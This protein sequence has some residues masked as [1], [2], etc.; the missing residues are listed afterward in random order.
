MK[1]R[2]R[3]SSVGWS[4]FALA[5]GAGLACVG[6]ARSEDA[7]QVAPEPAFHRAFIIRTRP[8]MIVDS[9][10]AKFV[11]RKLNR[12]KRAGADLVILEI[13]SPGGRMDASLAIAEQLRRV[14]WARTVAYI[15]RE[16]ISGAAVVALGCDEIVMQPHARLGD[17]GVIVRDLDGQFH[18]APEKIQSYLIGNLRTLA[19]QK[20]RPPAIAEAMVNKQLVV[21]RATNRH[22]GQIH[23]LSAPEFN[24]LPDK[25]Q[26]DQGPPIQESQQGLFL[27]V[28]GERAVELQLAQACVEDDRALHDRYRVANVTV[29]N[30]TAIDSAV[31]ILNHPFLAG[32]LLVIGVI[33][34]VVELSAPGIGFG[35]LTSGLCFALFFWSHFLGGTSGWLEVILFIAG[36]TFLGM[37]LFVFPGFGVAGVTGIVLLLASLIMACIEFSP[38]EGVSLGTLGTTLGMVGGSGL[39]SVVGIAWV[40]KH[41]G[42]I[43]LL[44]GLTLAP[45]PP[46]DETPAVD[47][48]TGKPLPKLDDT[49][50][51]EGAWGVTESPLRPSGKAMF[52]DRYVDVDAAG[53]FVEKGKQVRITSIMGTRIIVHEIDETES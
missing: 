31:V 52:G 32:L 49:A 37:E 16:A 11:S 34:L 53:Y 22:T 14:D 1:S 25:D 24:E 15:P 48:K 51:H 38:R 45:P 28:G 46:R 18:Y 4:T 20:G 41:L 10:M 43:R 39:A 50:I 35:G 6:L 36:L 29:L 27:T 40:V 23:Y 44:R 9:Y 21:H 12:A 47:V 19:K 13:D 17:V 30:P 42:G 3:S 26:W 8:E 33:A 2:A 5:V 7:D